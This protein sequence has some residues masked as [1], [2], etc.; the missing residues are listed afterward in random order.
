MSEPEE[1]NARG[2]KNE[3]V[4]R[5]YPQLGKSCPV[6]TQ[7]TCFHIAACLSRHKGACYFPSRQLIR[8][9]VTFYKWK[10]HRSSAVWIQIS[11]FFFLL[12][13]EG[14]SALFLRT[15]TTQTLI[16]GV[17]YATPLATPALL[18]ELLF[19]CFSK[20][21]KRFDSFHSHLLLCGTKGGRQFIPI[22]FVASSASGRLLA[23]WISLRH[24]AILTSP[25][26]RLFTCC[27]PSPRAMR[28]IFAFIF[29][30][31]DCSKMPRSPTHSLSHVIGSASVCLFMHTLE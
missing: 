8:V 9:S 22:A 3:T 30:S 11:F 2:S 20:K 6:L 21:K 7:L 16:A 19:N 5:R 13:K 28:V 31:P 10:D 27:R 4:P 15:P 14:Q 29:L 18:S 12:G 23:S 24:K 25:H 1:K 26:E 17:N